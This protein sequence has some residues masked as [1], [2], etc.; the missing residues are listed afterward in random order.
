MSLFDFFRKK[1]KEEKPKEEKKAPKI[2]VEEKPRKIKKEKAVE[3]RKEIHPVKSSEAGAKQF[4][5]VK[6]KVS[7]PRAKIS[8]TAYRVLKS[9]HVSEK[10]T[11][12]VAKNQYTFKILPRANKIE[13]KKAVEGLYNVDVIGVRIINVHRRHRRLGRITGWKKGYK[14][15]IVKVKEGQKIEVLPR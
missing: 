9:P 10:A 14:K 15:A 11:D 8:G 5:R 2:R 7:K 6:P 13:V 3:E 4:N 1:K 12:L